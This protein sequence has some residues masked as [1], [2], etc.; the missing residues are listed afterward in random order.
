[1]QQF[2][3][4]TVA[5]QEENQDHDGSTNV[6]NKLGRKVWPGIKQRSSYASADLRFV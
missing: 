1:M 5:M 3:M 2:K 4:G 6:Q